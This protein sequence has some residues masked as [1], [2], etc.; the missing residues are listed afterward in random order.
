MPEKLYYKRNLPHFQPSN[1]IYF[2]TF[3][4]SNSLPKNVIKELK[5]EFERIKNTNIGQE[6]FLKFNQLLDTSDTGSLWLKT[7]DVA[8][9][10]SQAIHYRDQKEYDLYC[11][12][13]MPNHVHIIFDVTRFAESSSR[14]SVSTYNLAK[15]MQNLKKY[16]A[17]ESNKVL[18]RTG[19]F[20]HHESYDHVIRD[21]KE[22]ENTIIYVIQNPVKAGLVTD[23]KKWRWSYLKE[24]LSIII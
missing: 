15:L 9:I 19:Q 1:S 14:N 10:I 22:L 7:N 24:T 4:L 16:T 20:W 3:R 8:E 5:L 11:Y 17:L 23:Y 13:I 18:K 12:C 2:V 21:N 6:Y